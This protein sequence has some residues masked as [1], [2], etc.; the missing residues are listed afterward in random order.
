MSA[1]LL[2][3]HSG[4]A[5]SLSFVVMPSREVFRERTFFLIHRPGFCLLQATN[6]LM[7]G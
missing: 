3:A 7:L 1:L 2:G 5:T 4:L 6:M